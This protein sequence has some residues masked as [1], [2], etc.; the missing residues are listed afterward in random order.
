VVNGLLDMV[1]VATC[2]DMVPL[3]GE[4]R[5]FAYWGL[6]VLRKSPRAGLQ[7]LFA[8]LKTNQKHLTEDDIGFTLGPRINAASRMGMPMDA[9]RLLSTS[10]EAEA[11]Q[12]ALHLD[13]INDERK[14]LVA[15]MV[16]E[17]RK[18]VLERHPEM[19][20]MPPIIVAGNPSWRPSLLGLAA[21]TLMEEHG[22]PV[23][24]WGREG[25]RA[26][27]EEPLLKGSCR[28]DG[29]MSV[30]EIMRAVPEGVFVE[31]G[32]HRAAG[33]FAVTV[34]TVDLLEGALLAAHEKISK[35]AALSEASA[36]AG[37]AGTLFGD[38]EWVDSRLSLA[39]ANWRTYSVIERL[40]PFGVGNP[41]PLFL[42]E[43]SEVLAVKHFGK[44]KNHLELLLAKPDGGKIPAISFFTTAE[45]FA[46][47]PSVAGPNRSGVIV[48]GSRVNLVGTLEKSMFRNFPELRLRIVDIL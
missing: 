22:R 13:H 41:K 27:G 30:V 36:S 34:A 16:K 28:S 37:P 2:A 5:V 26:S 44:E 17:I 40:A 19:S 25:E 32:G 18:K 45:D 4:N 14:G 24:L 47:R 3:Q 38:E 1:G 21:N 6:K 20:S 23:F 46:T 43:H 39:E 15:S 48:A 9:F 42:F 7:K 8:H 12:L 10:D 31:M 33:G 29:N 11:G 35:A